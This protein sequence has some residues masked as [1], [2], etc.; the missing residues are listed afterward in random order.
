MLVTCYAHKSTLVYD[1]YLSDEC[2]VCEEIKRL[3]DKLHLLN[4]FVLS[5]EK[6]AGGNG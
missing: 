2:P 1:D 4:N 5:L 6:F 3:E